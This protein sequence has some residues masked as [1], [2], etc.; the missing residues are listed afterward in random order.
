MRFRSISLSLLFLLAL[1]IPVANIGCQQVASYF[2]YQWMDNN[3]GDSNES[4]VIQSIISDKQDIKVGDNV[5]LSANAI[6]NKDS[7]TE[8]KYFWF[9]SAGSL[10]NPTS[11]STAWQTPDTAGTVTLSLMVEDSDGNKDTQSL[12]LTVKAAT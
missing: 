5:T 9:V 10:A 4:P 8:L 6:D 2:L 1:Y 12:Q 7:A 3:F 11:Q